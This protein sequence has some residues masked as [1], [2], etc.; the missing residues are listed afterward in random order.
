MRVLILGGTEDANRLAAAL[1]ERGIDALYSYAGRTAV[2]APQPLAVRKGG[3]GGAEGLAR[4]LDQHGY[5]HV[6]DATHPFAGEMSRNA[7]A[8]CQSSGVACLALERPEWTETPGDRWI[9]VPDLEAAAAAL[10][11]ERSHIFLAI[12]RQHVSAFASRPQHVY[13]LRFVDR[14]EGDPPLAGA[15]VVVERGPFSIS[16]E[17]DLLRRHGIQWL[18]TRNAG[19]VG[20]H[21]KLIA[22]RELGVPVIMIARPVLP[23][24]RRV[25]TV[26]EVLSWLGHEAC[27]GA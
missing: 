16:G 1:A 2:P 26:D 9:H 13:T 6:I 8:A 25:A 17:R 4:F 20:A 24:R 10:P 22:A 15:R 11:E 21:A 7:V 14:L 3:F 18:V 5:T 12:G 23:E 19:G 27:L